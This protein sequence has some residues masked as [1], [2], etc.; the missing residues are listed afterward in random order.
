MD[1]SMEEKTIEKKCYIT[2]KFLEF[3]REARRRSHE[4]EIYMV[5]ELLAE[6]SEKE[7]YLRQ[8][9]ADNE[10]NFEPPK[11]N[12]YSDPVFQARYEEWWNLA[13]KA[14]AANKR[15]QPLRKKYGYIF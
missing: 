10:Q 2:E 12:E 1:K 8:M 14:I 9:T 13:Q 6:K 15:M 5:N 7:A 11:E 3:Q 4:H